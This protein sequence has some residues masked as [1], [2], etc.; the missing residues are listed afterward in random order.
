MNKDLESISKWVHQWT[1]LFSP[2]SSKQATEVYFLW[3]YGPIYDL[4]LTF[5]KNAAQMCAVQKHLNQFLDNE[6]DF[7]Y[8]ADNKIK[9]CNKIIGI[10]EQLT[11]F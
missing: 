7:N 1:M 10:I 9:T 8:H 11:H 3:K 5:N 2:D 6:L 4:P